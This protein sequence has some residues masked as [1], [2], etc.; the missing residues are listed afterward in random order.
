[1]HFDQVGSNPNFSKIACVDLHSKLLKEFTVILTQYQDKEK[2]TCD[3][4]NRC[5][6]KKCIGIQKPFIKKD[7]IHSRIRAKRNVLFLLK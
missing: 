7:K 5:R 6:K 4:F 1:M 2:K 3:H